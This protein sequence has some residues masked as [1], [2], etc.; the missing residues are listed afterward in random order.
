M[1]NA[2]VIAVGA[3]G[4]FGLLLYGP[5]FAHEGHDKTPGAIAAPHG[6]AVQGTSSLYWELLSDSSGLKLYPLTHDL[7]PIEPKSISLSGTASFPKKPKAE[8]V[9]FAAQS[10]HFSAQVNSKG[11]HRYTLSLSF[12]YKGKK[13]KVKFQVEPQN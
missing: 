6:G 5:V 3:F 8:P 9:T 11:S 13:E 10:D 4:V 12:T 2:F 7:T 1:K